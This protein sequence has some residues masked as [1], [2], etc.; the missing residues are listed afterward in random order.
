MID[1]WVDG[2]WNDKGQMEGGRRR[3]KGWTKDRQ[4]IDMDI[5]NEN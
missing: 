2:G 5:E 1:E 3:D 4:R